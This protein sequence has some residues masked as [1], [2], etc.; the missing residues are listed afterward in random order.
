MNCM[1]SVI[2]KITIKKKYKKKE[3]TKLLKT[4]H[5][6]KKKKKEKKLI[7]IKLI[8]K[9]LNIKKFFKLLTFKNNIKKNFF[10]F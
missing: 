4:R 6:K 2:I 8:I 9:Y 3:N 1:I 7:Y 10:F 5:N